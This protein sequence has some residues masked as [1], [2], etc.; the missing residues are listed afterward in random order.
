M[1][2]FWAFLEENGNANEAVI[3][4]LR[5]TNE[6]KSHTKS[7]KP[8][9]AGDVR[10]PTHFLSFSESL[11]VGLLYENVYDRQVALCIIVDFTLDL[12]CQG[13]VEYSLSSPPEIEQLLCK[14]N[15]YCVKER[16]WEYWMLARQRSVLN[17][18]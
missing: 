17:S 15:K 8:S 2:R 10:N 16:I 5:K 13:F 14:L 4:N 9:W 11:G 6:A 7:Q 12:Q 3:E 1:G 18:I